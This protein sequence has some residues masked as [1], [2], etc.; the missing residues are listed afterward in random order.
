MTTSTNAILFYGYCWNVE[1]SRPWE[2]DSANDNPDAN[3]DADDEDDETKDW[4]GRYAR[5]K[6]CLP[7]STPFP[8]RRVTPTR[9][10][11]WN[12]TPTDYS[13]AEQTIV[14]RHIAY[15]DVKEKLVEAALCCV[16]THCSD[17]HPMPYVAVK[18]S[19]TISSRGE[20]REIATLAVDPTWNEALAEF[21]AAMGIKTD[22]LKAA[23]WLVS[24][25][26]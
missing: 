14:D 15:W 8:A 7:P 13:D 23:W 9:E 4:E 19:R 3:E 2:I 12:S 10:N 11:G 24:N 26:D 5:T 1:S 6:G 22:G 20:M 21:C 25:W 16:D 17:K 18:A